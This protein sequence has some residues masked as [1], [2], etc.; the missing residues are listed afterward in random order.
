MLV[1]NCLACA[2]R[3]PFGLA[4]RTPHDLRRLLSTESIERVRPHGL[5][6]V[7]TRVVGAPMVI[8]TTRI[9]VMAN[10]QEAVCRIITIGFAVTGIAE[11]PGGT[12]TR[13]P[14]CLSGLT[15]IHSSMAAATTA[16]LWTGDIDDPVRI[17]QWTHT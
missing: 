6:V 3:V 15:R 5:T 1:E 12:V 14:R 11:P 8:E 10:V 9:I 7:G 13:P 2:S 4:W 17:A 16:T